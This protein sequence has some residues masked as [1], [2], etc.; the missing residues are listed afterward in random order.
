MYTLTA[1]LL[2]LPAFV[3]ATPLDAE[4]TPL[5]R[6][7]APPTDQITITDTS[8]S[9]NGCPQGS[10]STSISPDK[11]VRNHLDVPEPY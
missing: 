4:F 9:G 5:E 2:L 11:T 6:R 3:I 7:Q 1:A 8:T 10:V